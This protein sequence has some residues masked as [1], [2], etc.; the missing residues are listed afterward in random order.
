MRGT[1][2]SVV[3]DVYNLVMSTE[4]P[5]FISGSVYKVERPLNSTLEDMV[6]MFRTGLDGRLLDG[7]T[8]EG[9]LS[10]NIFVP[11][12]DN[13]MGVKT[14]NIERLEQIET[15]IEPLLRGTTDKYIYWY[16]DMIQS[17]REDTINQSFIYVDLRYRMQTGNFK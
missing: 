11:F 1:S 5:N 13:G 7:N 8:Q 14:P 2:L 6:I 10:I 16:G 15:F 9:A 12:I 3:S 17:F 4:I